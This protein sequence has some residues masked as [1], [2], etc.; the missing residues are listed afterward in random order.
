MIDGTMFAWP[1]Y[2]TW[3]STPNTSLY[4]LRCMIFVL[5]LEASLPFYEEPYRFFNL[6]VFEC[7]AKSSNKCMPGGTFLVLSNRPKAPSSC[8]E[9]KQLGLKEMTIK[10]HGAFLQRLFACFC[11]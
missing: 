9:Q 4:D 5:H 1:R 2:A 8:I 6:D 10:L 3:R 7:S 11:C